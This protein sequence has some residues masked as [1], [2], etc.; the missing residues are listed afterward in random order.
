ML[1]RAAWGFT[2]ETA[3][4]GVRMVLS[5]V[6]DAYPN[7]KIILGHLGE[8]LPFLLWRIDMGFA[9]GGG[10]R[11]FRDVFCEHF[12][13]TTSGFFSNPALLCC[14]QELG[15]DR[16]MFS[17]D[18][19]FVAQQAGHRLAADH[20]A[21]RRGQG[22]D[23]QRQRDATA[24]AVTRSVRSSRGA[25]RRRCDRRDRRRTRRVRRLDGPLSVHHRTRPQAA[26]VSRRLG[27]RRASRA[28]LP[29]PR[30]D[31]GRADRRQAVPRAA[32]PMPRS[33][34]A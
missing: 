6:F 28:G 26:A 30:L 29:E 2:V 27:R 34:R 20:P 14:V 23:R 19:P 16:I 18:Y 8:G 5:G 9:R 22:E 10:S 3:T 1:L 13:I 15:V 12:Y 17:V 24:E 31:G 7:L 4:Q 32:S 25:D 33:C 21:L 11:S